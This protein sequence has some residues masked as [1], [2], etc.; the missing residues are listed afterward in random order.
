MTLEDC[1][2]LDARVFFGFLAFFVVSAVV[3]WVTVT[4][5]LGRT[6]RLWPTV[7]ATVM[8]IVLGVGAL[9]SIEDD[10]QVCRKIKL[11]KRCDER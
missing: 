1:A 8:L 10:M 11:D 2:A 6:P 7:L 9:Q 5:T 3:I 4:G